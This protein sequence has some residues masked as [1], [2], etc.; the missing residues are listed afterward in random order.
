MMTRL[1]NII[2]VFLVCSALVHSYFST[3]ACVS[4]SQRVTDLMTKLC[5]QTLEAGE[6]LK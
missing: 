4:F 6:M 3:Y 5:T 1:V 2:V